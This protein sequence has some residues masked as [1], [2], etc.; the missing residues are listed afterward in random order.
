MNSWHS[1]PSIFNLGH[2]AIKDLFSVPV[3]V[4]EKVDGSQ[5]S[6]G[7][8]EEGELHVR[9]KGAVMVVDAPEKMFQRAVD[10]VKELKPLLHPGWTYRAEYLQK[11]KHNSL[12]YDRIPDKHLIL[13]DVT[14]D[15]ET[16]LSYPA[17]AEEA[18]RLGLECVALLDSGTEITADI[19]R[20]IID[21][22]VSVL[23]GQKIEGVVIKPQAYN[24]YGQ[25][26]KVLMGKFVSE[27]FKEIHSNEWKKANPSRGDIVDSIVGSLKTEA[28]WHKAVQH[29]REAGKIEDSPR[30][31]GAIMKEIQADVEKECADE[32]KERLFKFAM[33]IIRRRVTAGAAE[34]YK[35]Q[36]LKQ[37]F[38]QPGSE[39]CVVTLPGA[40]G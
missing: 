35:E 6:F 34:W 28:R 21:N 37:Q 36:L 20:N 14:T 16:Y 29:L 2:R 8:D 31:I 13:F 30:D 24:L 15:H 1:Y 40:V 3:I 23:G 12:A 38:D 17:K 7:V 5:F 27:R 19:L 25:D 32:I 18:H 33:P 10:T 11:P 4:E 9:S 26:K 22:T 39:D